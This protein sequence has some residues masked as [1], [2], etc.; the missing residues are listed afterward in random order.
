MPD[1]W[2]GDIGMCTRGALFFGDILAAL[3]VVD[4]AARE[5]VVAVLVEHVALH[6]DRC[7]LDAEDSDPSIIRHLVGEVSLTHQPDRG[8]IQAT[9]RGVVSGLRGDDRSAD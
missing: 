4:L 7:P 2:P 5:A 9:T 6:R 1:L 3:E 8:R